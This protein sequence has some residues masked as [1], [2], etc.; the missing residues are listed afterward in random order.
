MNPV[1]NAFFSFAPRGVLSF[2]RL[3]HFVATF[4]FFAMPVGR[5]GFVLAATHLLPKRLHGRDRFS[6]RKGL[7]LIDN[8]HLGNILISDT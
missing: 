7:D 8:A 3:D 2:A 6:R 4:Q 1:A 5:F